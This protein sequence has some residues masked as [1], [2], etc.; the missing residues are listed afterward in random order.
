M[1]AVTQQSLEYMESPKVNFR[2][3]FPPALMRKSVAWSCFSLIIHAERGNGCLSSLGK[4]WASGHQDH[5]Q[6]CY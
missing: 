3:S 2:V 1:L 5:S 6:G 4:P